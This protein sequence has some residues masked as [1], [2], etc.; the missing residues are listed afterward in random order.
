MPIS[1]AEIASAVLSIRES[2]EVSDE[3]IK[4]VT[5]ELPLMIDALSRIPEYR[6]IASDLYWVCE[7]AKSYREN[8]KVKANEMV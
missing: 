7:R 8:R 1:G 4:I 3:E 5:R 2:P 6:L